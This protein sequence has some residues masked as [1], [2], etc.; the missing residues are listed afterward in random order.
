MN[1]YNG[2][3]AFRLGLA[4]SARARPT[5]ESTSSIVMPNR[6]VKGKIARV[7][8]VCWTFSLFAFPIRRC[9]GSTTTASQLRCT[10]YKYDMS[11][12]EWV[13]VQDKTVHPWIKFYIPLGHPQSGKGIIWLS[14]LTNP[15]AV[16]MLCSCKGALGSFTPSSDLM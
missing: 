1:T 8:R 2:K 4:A 3:Y 11:K 15:A 16:S 10:L 7:R 13:D 6:R 5:S 12:E 14:I 9:L